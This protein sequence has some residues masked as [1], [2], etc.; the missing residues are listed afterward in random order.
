MYVYALGINADGTVTSPLFKK[1][2]TI[3]AAPTITTTP[4]YSY[5]N[6]LQIPVQG[7]T[8]DVTYVVENP[9]EGGEVTCIPPFGVEWVHDCVVSDGKVTFTV[10]SNEAATPGSDPRVAYLNL[11]YTGATDRATITIS[12]AAP[13]E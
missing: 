4:E 1:I 11:E 12:Q 3:P 6:P 2:V 10:D 13:T 7:G 5:Y 9:V 8:F